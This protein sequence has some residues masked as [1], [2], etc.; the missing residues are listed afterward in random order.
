[1]LACIIKGGNPL[2][3]LTWT[4]FNNGLSPEISGTTVTKTV[5]WYTTRGADRSGTC[6]SS[7]S[8]AGTQSVS[9]N[10]QVLCKLSFCLF[11]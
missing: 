5:I 4:C 7:H 2:A 11:K 9:V 10:V 6:Q 3:T 8:I 1:M